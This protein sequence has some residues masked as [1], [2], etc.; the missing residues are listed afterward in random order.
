LSRYGLEEADFDF[1]DTDSDSLPD[2][3]ESLHFGGATNANP[4]AM[5]SNGV[6]TVREAWIADLNPTSPASFFAITAVSNLPPWTLYFIGSSNRHY[7]LHGRT[8]LVSGIWTNAPG[9]GGGDSIPD[10]NEPPHGPFYR[11]GVELP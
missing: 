10:T 7:T 2:W 9:A 4:D 8:N 11:L 6:N 5:A 1:S 3:W